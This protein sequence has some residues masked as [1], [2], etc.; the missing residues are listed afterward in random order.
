MSYPRTLVIATR[1]AHKLEELR[2][3]LKD[4]DI[5][6]LGLD[7]IR[8]VPA[9]VDETGATFAANACLKAVVYGRAAGFPTLADDSGL[10]VDALD[11]APG[12]YS[13]RYAGAGA[14]DADNNAKLLA[15][16][17]HVPDGERTGRFRCALALYLPGGPEAAR[18]AHNAARATGFE[19]H[20]PDA[21]ADAEIGQ[22]ENTL[23]TQVADFVICTEA[24]TEG[25]VMR[26]ESGTD[27]F[28][29][30]PL[31]FSRDLGCSF[32]EAG[33][34]KHRV[35]HRARALRKLMGLLGTDESR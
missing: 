6:V 4:S 31:F 7:D 1:N 10:E 35:S 15:A 5:Q 12:I 17:D 22:V 29:Y 24:T 3:K 8:G 20:S 13:A 34:L 16:I 18:L 19:V 33:E 2:D 27:G 9:D 25:T 23:N 30:D 26:T 14:T 11:G 21:F 28:G 32:A